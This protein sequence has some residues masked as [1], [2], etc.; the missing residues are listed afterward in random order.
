MTHKGNGKAHT[1]RFKGVDKNWKVIDVCLC[2][3][4]MRCVIT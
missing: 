2:T 4:F 3:L 1:G